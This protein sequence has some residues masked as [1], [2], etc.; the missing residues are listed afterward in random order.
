[1]ECLYVHLVHFFFLIL[2]NCEQKM[3][4]DFC[5][6]MLFDV[7]A[8]EVKSAFGASCFVIVIHLILYLNLSLGGE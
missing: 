7:Y 4:L 2:R 3:G 6:S 1:M 5:A 8:Q